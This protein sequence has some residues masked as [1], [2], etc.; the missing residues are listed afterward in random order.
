MNALDRSRH[1]GSSQRL[2]ITNNL[3]RYV[4]LWKRTKTKTHMAFMLAKPTPRTSTMTMTASQC[5]TNMTA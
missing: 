1:A 4:P 2:P 3:Q 5:S